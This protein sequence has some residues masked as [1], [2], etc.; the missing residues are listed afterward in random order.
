MKFL[1]EKNN[2]KTNESAGEIGGLEGSATEYN[3]Y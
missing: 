2:E 3:E 1:M